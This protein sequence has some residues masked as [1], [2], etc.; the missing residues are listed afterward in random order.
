MHTPRSLRPAVLAVLAVVALGVPAVAASG[1]APAPGVKPVLG[2]IADDYPRALAEAKAR[3]LPL[4]IES[5]AP[6]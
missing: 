4:F 1:G 5:W 6:W 2:F 3:K